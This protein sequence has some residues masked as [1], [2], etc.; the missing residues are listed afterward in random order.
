MTAELPVP[1]V[2][3]DPQPS[4]AMEHGGPEVGGMVVMMGE[5]EMQSDQNCLFVA[6]YAILS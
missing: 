4:G 5:E 6:K 3:T 2:I 1:F